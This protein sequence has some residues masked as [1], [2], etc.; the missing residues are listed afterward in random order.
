LKNPAD[1]QVVKL[2]EAW[3]KA[4]I[5]NL[6]SEPASAQ[7]MATQMLLAILTLHLWEVRLGKST[8]QQFCGQDRINMRLTEYWQAFCDQTDQQFREVL[9]IVSCA[10]SLLQS[11]VGSLYY[12]KPD[13]FL[14]VSV[15]VLGRV[16][17][18]SL[19]KPGRLKSRRSGG[20]YYTPQP[21]VDYVVRSTISL[22]LAAD[23]TIP[24]VL[25]PACGGG[26]FLLSTYQYLLEHRSTLDF[27][28]QDLSSYIHGV[29]IDPIGVAITQASLW[30]QSIEQWGMGNHSNRM[31]QRLKTNIRCGNAVIDSDSDLSGFNWQSVFPEILS[32][33]GFDLVIGNPPY[34]DAELMSSD[35]PNWRTYCAQQ[36]QTATGNWDLFCVFIEK[37]LQLCR[38]GGFTSLVVPNKLLS[39]GYAAA[40]RQL[41]RQTSQLQAIR[42]YSTV[43]VFE[44]SVYPVVYI[45]QK[46]NQGDTAR[47]L[48]EKMLTIE[49]IGETHWMQIKHP[50]QPWLVTGSELIQQ[51][52]QLTKLDS[53]TAVVGAAT[54]AEAYALTHWIQTCPTPEPSDLRLVNS[55]TIDRYRNLW[56]Q[57]RLRYLGQTYQHPIVAAERLLHL[58]PK[59]LD[60]ARQP[61][62]IVAGMS[63]RLE[64][65]LDQTGGILAGKSTSVIRQ[66]DIVDLRYLL[67]LLNSRLLSFYL[68]TRF[69]GNRLQGGYLRIG[70]PQLRQLPIVVP[71]LNQSCQK[72]EYGQ[73]I[74]LVDQ[75]INFNSVTDI[76]KIHEIDSKIDSI[77]YQI[78]QL[79]ST[80]IIQVEALISPNA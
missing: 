35:Y 73:I 61:K 77:V 52:D 55:G 4:L 23:T 7:L 65:I 46:I 42:D 39:A 12:P 62:I 22:H 36:Y 45:T 78:Y 69:G 75:L 31:L 15:G 14:D 41:L 54:V 68:L 66:T 50:T 56:G 72:S 63:Q 20:I 38:S 48:Y 71:V 18:Q 44:A 24:Q 53:I 49:Q 67:G 1:A 11:I 33:G 32:D 10:D 43:A 13:Q 59:R 37:A 40:T 57:K 21:V 3:Q 26:A 60:Q 58:S 76:K 5:V 74:D 51:L 19:A 30:L 2:A 47:F 25:D 79:S 6:R 80:E 28:H 70:P 34:M 27:D 8:L 29:D 17:E 9:P 64:C 16:Y